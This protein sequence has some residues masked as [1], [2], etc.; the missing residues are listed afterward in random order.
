MWNYFLF[1]YPIPFIPKNVKYHVAPKYFYSLRKQDYLDSF[2]RISICVLKIIP[3]IHNQHLI[4]F[5]Y[6]ILLPCLERF[7][8]RTDLNTVKYA[9]FKKQ[10]ATFPVNKRLKKTDWKPVM[11]SERSYT[12]QLLKALFA[13]VMGVCYRSTSWQAYHL[14]QAVLLSTYVAVVCRSS[15]L[16]LRLA[17]FSPR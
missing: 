11:W 13:F 12:M 1:S 16:N 3:N 9:L 17:L 4:V 2:R 7:R 6:P 8:L 5:L 10:R 14:V 15:H